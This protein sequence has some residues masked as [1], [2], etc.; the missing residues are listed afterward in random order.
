MKLGDAGAAHLVAR[1]AA[2]VQGRQLC[3]RLSGQFHF[4][5]P[6][7][8]RVQG[9]W[10]RRA[11]DV[12]LHLLLDRVPA[13]HLFVLRRLQLVIERKREPLILVT[14]ILIDVQ[15]PL[16]E[17][18]IEVLDLAVLPIDVIQ[19]V[20]LARHLVQ[21]EASGQ[22][23]RFQVALA[24]MI[25]RWSECVLRLR[26]L[27]VLKW[28]CGT[29]QILSGVAV[30]ILVAVR[31]V[32]RRL[33]RLMLFAEIDLRVRLVREQPLVGLRHQQRL[34]LRRLLLPQGEPV[35]LQEVLREPERDALLDL[36]YLHVR[37]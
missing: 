9:P 6:V 3:V 20:L 4:A 29:M 13:I 25:R 15:L 24:I 10:F 22:R 18:L 27:R 5:I 7:A 19:V 36:V 28:I 34:R 32:V 2:V 12:V 21:V 8:V 37:R 1:A 26:W 17:P 14:P 11:A 30:E 16:H 35:A 33:Q 31:V 23:H